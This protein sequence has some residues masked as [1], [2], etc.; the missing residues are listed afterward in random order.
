MACARADGS[1]RGDKSAADPW[2]L[3]QL[4]LHAEGG[5]ARW[6]EAYVW[7][8][9]TL[10]P[11][12]LRE[13]ERGELLDPEYQ[14]SAKPPSPAQP[15]QPPHPRPKSQGAFLQGRRREEGVSLER[16]E[17]EEED[18]GQGKRG[19]EGANGPGIGEDQ[20]PRLSSEVILIRDPC[21]VRR[22]GAWSGG[23]GRSHKWSS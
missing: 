10:P 22:S 17:R 8:G 5:L 19:N 7:P 20:H 1:Q 14:L 15:S 4:C 13:W 18:R 6:K 12:E 23:G 9:A 11:A 3:E 21:W 16:R 2:T